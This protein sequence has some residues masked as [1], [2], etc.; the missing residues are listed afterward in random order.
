V[1]SSLLL[2]L[3]VRVIGK[4]IGQ[5]VGQVRVLGQVKGWGSSVKSSIKKR[6]SR[7]GGV[8]PIT[9]VHTMYLAHIFAV[10]L[11]AVI[12]DH[13]PVHASSPPTSACLLPSKVTMDDLVEFATLK[14]HPDFVRD[15]RWRK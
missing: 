3:G 10:V 11:L 2:F 12:I 9:T 15:K 7:I 4:V 14:L 13:V 1:S 5:V 8:D 6:L